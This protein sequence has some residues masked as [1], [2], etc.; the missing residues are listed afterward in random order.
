MVDPIARLA[1]MPREER[2]RVIAKLQVAAGGG[3]GLTKVDE[4][5]QV[6]AQKR[7]A[8][9]P[10]S[11][12]QEQVWFLTQLAPGSPHYDVPFRL[13][14]NGPLEV[15]ALT[16]ALSLMTAR[17]EILRTSLHESPKGLVQVVRPHIDPELDVV[18][19]AGYPDPDDEAERKISRLTG[20]GL[21]L[22]RPPLW[23]AQLLRLDH[24]GHRH[25]LVCVFSHAIVDGWSI[26]LLLHELETL[27][28]TLRVGLA[29]TDPNP[30]LQFADYTIW[31][32]EQ[33]TSGRWD[34]QL[35]Y[36]TEQLDGCPPL[37][38]PADRSRPAVPS[39]RGRAHTFRVPSELS[40]LVADR[41]R[42][43]GVTPFT[44]YFAAYQALLARWCEQ[45]DIAVG[46][47]VSG[48]SRPEL[49]GV[50]GPLANMVVLRTDLS[51]DP[52]VRELF[53]RVHQTILDA[54]DHEEL[55]FGK[56]VEK[57]RPV[58]RSAFN[59]IC[60]TVFTYGNSSF[61]GSRVGLTSDMSMH[62]SG[63]SNG[64]VRFDFQLS[65]D[66]TSDSLDGCLDYSLDLLLPQTAAALCGAY[67]V[68]LRAFVDNIDVP[69]SRLPLPGPAQWRSESD[70]G[71][72]PVDSPL[73]PRTGDEPAPHGDDPPHTDTERSLA[74]L[75]A[76]AL[77]LE[78]I[79]VQDDFFA[80]GGHSLLA[81]TLVGRICQ[82]LDVDLAL[83]DFF[84]GACTVAGVG[85]VVDELLRCTD[86]T[87]NRLVGDPA[88]G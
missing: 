51:G 84:L 41:S 56:I 20:V 19:L 16:R 48:R 23:R 55:S 46:T 45:D 15:D 32:R 60:Q 7:S 72:R 13:L 37:A 42:G 11:F 80:L 35:A 85:E 54:F 9:L 10:A 53:G 12:A 1:L 28:G 18:D 4:S 49:E 34:H 27:Y 24:E 81:A 5:P 68:T 22:S 64:T 79:G 73:A 17:Y 58:R 62:F 6:R 77:G 82:E 59:P 71:R 52:T 66:Q 39:F 33:L 14:I 38:F 2:M 76:D 86:Q 25:L 74:R 29:R 70:Q 75:W 57:L 83:A 61:P 31:Q 30:P 69:L 44:T 36:W 21:E 3:V 87:M 63:L 88:I 67:V 8:V 65:L 26:G 50:V 47:L 43:I 78:H 40:E